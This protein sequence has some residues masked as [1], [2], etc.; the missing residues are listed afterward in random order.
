MFCFVLFLHRCCLSLV[1]SNTWKEGDA[2]CQQT[3][4]TSL[5][6]AHQYLVPWVG[7][8]FFLAACI[9]VEPWSHPTLLKILLGQSVSQEEGTY[10]V[11][12]I[13]HILG[14][15]RFSWS[16]PPPHQTFLAL[17]TGTLGLFFTKLPIRSLVSYKCSLHTLQI[18]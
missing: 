16:S 9:A 7:H 1:I 17:N 14:S 13:G 18:F 6:T 8:G 3:I 12:E 4:C 11:V 2:E 15:K 5:L 10:R